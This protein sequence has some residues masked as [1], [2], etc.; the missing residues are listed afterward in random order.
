[1][2]LTSYRSYI[3]SRTL[4]SRAGYRRHL[5]GAALTYAEHLLPLAACL[6]CHCSFSIT[7]TPKEQEPQSW[8]RSSVPR[9]ARLLPPQESCR[10]GRILVFHTPSASN[11][12]RLATFILSMYPTWNRLLPALECKPPGGRVG[13]ASCALLAVGPSWCVIQ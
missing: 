6:Q 7:G 4:E 3:S 2:S 1:M 8:S 12:Q 13:S 9:L 5:G 11:T 10:I